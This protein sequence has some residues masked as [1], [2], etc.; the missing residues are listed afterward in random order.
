MV[1]RRWLSRFVA[2]SVA[3]VM[4]LA[5]D[6]A[7]AA[8]SSPVTIL[9]SA[10]NAASP[11]V[12]VDREGDTLLAWTE[13]STSYPYTYRLL[14]RQRSRTGVFGSTKV[15]SPSGQVP[16]APRVA[17]DDDG[18][19]VVVWQAYSKD[20]YRIYAR[21]VSRTGV[22]GP[23]LVMSAATPK[24]FLADVAIDSDGDALVVWNEWRSDGTTWPMVRRFRRDGT[25]GPITQ[26]SKTARNAEAPTVAIDRQ[27]D[28]LIGWADDNAVY[29]RTLSSTGVYSAV[30]TASPALSPIDRYFGAR[31]AVDRYGNGIVVFRRWE[32]ATGNSTV[33]SRGMS[34]VGDL[35]TLRTL[36]PSTHKVSNHVVASDLEG[37]VVIAWDRTDATGLHARRI[38]RTGTVGS[39]VQLGN[40]RQPNLAV[41]DD[42]D[43]VV[44]WQGR[45]SANTVN[46]VQT[47]RVSRGG[48]FG[49]AATISANGEA[50]RLDVT[51]T[52]GVVVAWE[53]MFTVTRGIQ[54]ASG[55]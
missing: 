11:A 41:D 15:I 54:V 43:G 1:L 49:S 13:V 51:P 46:T 48:T 33:W 28:A 22:L 42:G 44:V 8:Y 27:G 39:I 23:V 34:P 37:D 2:A 4:V 5:A 17:L 45:N 50:P 9:S 12:G 36:S 47:I 24:A 10:W 16:K 30:R 19:A 35:G 18:D 21:R 52:G 6:P 29:A 3:S 55:P 26:L 38:A 32:A 14:V 40:G 20:T 25:T 31:V 53:R 7:F